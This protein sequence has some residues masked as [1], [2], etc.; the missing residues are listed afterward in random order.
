MPKTAAIWSRS[1][2]DADVR[3]GGRSSEHLDELRLEARRKCPASMSLG[4]GKFF[5]VVGQPCQRD[6]VAA[7]GGEVKPLHLR[8]VRRRATERNRGV[9]WIGSTT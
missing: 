7:L 8:H 2:G 4:V 9:C 5:E 3:W 6:P 1:T